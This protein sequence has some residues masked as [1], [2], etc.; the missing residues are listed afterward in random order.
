MSDYTR[1]ELEQ[2]LQE[3]IGEEEIASQVPT[4][5][6]LYER[7]IIDADDFEETLIKDDKQIIGKIRKSQSENKQIVYEKNFVKKTYNGNVIGRSLLYINHQTGSYSDS[8]TQ[9]TVKII[10]TE[11]IIPSVYKG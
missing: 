3:K 11:E 6:E 7:S 2:M 4:T 10:K 9:P 5:F 1:D 8:L